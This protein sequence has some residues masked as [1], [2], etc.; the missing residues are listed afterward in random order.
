V[1]PLRIGQFETLDPKVN[2]FWHHADRRLFLARRDGR[3]VGRVAC[4]DDDNHN[5]VHSE[6]LVFF[7]FFEADDEAV[8]R[9]LFAAVEGRA[10][11]RGRDAV[12]GP[13]NPTMND[14]AGF[15][16]DAF[17]ERPYVMM[18]QSPPEY[19][20]WTER[21]GYSKVKDLYTFYFDNRGGPAERLAKITERAYKRYP[22][23][24]RPAQL[25]NFDSEVAILKRLHAAAWENNW[26]NVPF[27]DAEM[28]H[29]A[30]ELK[31]I[32]D[33]DLVIFLELDGEPIGVAVTIPDINQVLARFNGRLFPTGIFHLLRRKKIINRARLVMLGVVPEY[34]NKGFDLLL[35]H[36]IVARAKVNGIVEG[37]C[38]WTLEDNDSINHGIE[39]AGGVRNKTYRIYQKQ[40]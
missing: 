22:L 37:E 39:A 38:G 10:R 40:L 27:T 24:I 5:T 32:V 23:K 15:Q 34:R 20:T 8:A 21:A 31:M 36:E 17:D 28:D 13:L 18:P 4:I 14:G 1:A 2:P 25:K 30:K 6:N 29:L 9:A 16:I 11:E 35:I 19:P 12:R 33:P 3:V 7:G 26:G